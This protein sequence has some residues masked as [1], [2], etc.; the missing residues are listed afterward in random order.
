MGSDLETLRSISTD[1]HLRYLM[2][3]LIIQDDS[4]TVDPFTAPELPSADLLY[5]IWP[6]NDAGIVVSDEIGIAELG[7]MLRDQS[8]RPRVIRI[9]DYRIHKGNL[10]LCAETARIKRLFSETTSAAAEPVPLAVLTKD[11]FESA[12]LGVTSL[13]MRHVESTY[14]E[15]AVI[16]SAKFLKSH[17]EGWSVGSAAITEAVIETSATALE[18]RQSPFSVLTSAELFLGREARSYWLEEV[19]YRAPMLKNFSLKID[20]LLG[21]DMQEESLDPSLVVP[22]LTEFALN[23]PA[24]MQLVQTMLISSKESLTHVSFRQVYLCCG[25]TWRELLSFLASECRALTSFTLRIVREESGGGP[26]VD[27]REVQYETLPELYRAGLHLDSRG[28][29]LNKRTT[30]VWYNGDYA[31]EILR[32][33]AEYGYVPE[34]IASGKRR[35]KS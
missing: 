5:R 7:Q 25:S 3:T 28:P 24:S 1:D 35:V 12:A 34:S 27:F 19:F 31:C 6:R 30:R 2:Y 29:G 23:G 9:R 10:E 11:I 16:H 26:A 8:L 33:L 15:Q 17:P 18:R 32:I 21:K 4:E 22:R 13:T 20:G 14:S